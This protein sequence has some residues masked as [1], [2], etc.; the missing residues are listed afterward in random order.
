[1]IPKEIQALFD[2]IDYLD[3]NKSEFI[4][5]IPLVNELKGLENKRSELKP[6]NNSKDKQQY[7]IIQKEIS[8]KFEPVKINI[9]N[10]VLEKLITLGIWNDDDTFASIWNNNIPAISE[11]KENFTDEDVERILQNKQKYLSFREETN[12][13]FLCL[14]FA[15]NKLDE[16]LKELFDFFKNTKENEFKNFETKTIKVGSFEE[17]TKVWI[18]NRGKNTRFFIPSKTVF[19]KPKI[20]QTNSTSIKN[21]IIMGDKIEVGNIPNNSGNISIGKDNQQNIQTTE[22]K[23]DDEIDRKSFIVQCW[24]FTVSIFRMIVSFFKCA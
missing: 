8:E 10:P 22:T 5:L 11:L 13:D 24:D 9:L 23:S 19:A 7:G 2:F 20:T 4:K 12:T 6:H 18:E 15:F 21:E 14:D 17:A 3:S 1:M 16:I